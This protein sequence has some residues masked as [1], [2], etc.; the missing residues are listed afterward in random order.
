MVC[1]IVGDARSL[2]VGIVR[3]PTL[4]IDRVGNIVLRTIKGKLVF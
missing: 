3:L 4:L 1:F 2:F